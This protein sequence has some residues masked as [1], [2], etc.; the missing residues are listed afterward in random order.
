MTLRK[1]RMLMVFGNR[2]LKEVCEPKSVQITGDS[3]KMYNE[4]I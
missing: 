4:E 2:T 1:E 3:R